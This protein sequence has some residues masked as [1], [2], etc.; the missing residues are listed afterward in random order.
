MKRVKLQSSLIAAVAYRTETKILRVELKS[1][2]VYRY[3]GVDEQTYHGLLNAES[4]G[5]FYNAR[6]RDEFRY[7]EESA[8]KVRR[9]T[10]GV[11]I[12]RSSGRSGADPIADCR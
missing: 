3:F 8:L 5:R 2:R 7:E 6:I 12:L 4:K 10:A 11:V 9:H 1:G